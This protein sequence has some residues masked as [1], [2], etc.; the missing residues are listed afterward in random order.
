MGNLEE[1]FEKKKIEQNHNRNGG[2]G[3]KFSVGIVN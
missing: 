2:Y 3:L 1:A